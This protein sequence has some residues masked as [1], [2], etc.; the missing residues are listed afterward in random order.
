MSASPRS[1]TPLR[2]ATGPFR[3][4]AAQ[5][6]AEWE[7]L[8]R[9][10]GKAL[11]LQ[12]SLTVCGDWNALG[13]AMERDAYDLAWMGG[14]LRYVQARARGAGP[15]IATVAVAGSPMCHAVV[16]AG[17]HVA[18]RDFPHDA[19]GLSMSFTHR[20][21]TTGWLAAYAALLAE[22]IDPESC[23]GYSDGRQHAENVLAVAEGTCD[24]ATDSERNRQ[25]MVERGAV[26]DADARVVWRSEALPQDPII[27]SNRLAPA[28]ALRVQQVLVSI[29]A[30]AA[31]A[32]PMPPGYSGFV[33]ATDATYAVIREA[34]DLV[35]RHAPHHA[36][37]ALRVE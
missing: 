1:E 14:G 36:I 2:F 19:L 13:E 29:D 28:L 23:F 4:T 26:A 33:A 6:H 16:I 8:V 37:H 18:V 35:Y 3:P 22:G 31:K 12:A 7:P 20:Q 5:T 21:S 24:L 15:A 17:R 10:L 30:K 27:A 25:S 11:G 32:I 34:L 9:F